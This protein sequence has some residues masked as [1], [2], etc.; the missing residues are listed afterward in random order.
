MLGRPEVEDEMYAFMR[1]EGGTGA[2]GDDE[3]RGR[4][5]TLDM[6]GRDIG[7]SER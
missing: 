4:R 5:G 2:P 1:T 3:T 6:S 7:L